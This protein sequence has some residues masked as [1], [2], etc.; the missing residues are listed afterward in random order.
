MPHQITT[1][2]PSQGGKG[3]RLLSRFANKPLIPRAERG[4]RRRTCFENPSPTCRDREIL[5]IT[6]NTEAGVLFRSIPA[7]GGVSFVISVV[8]IFSSYDSSET[9]CHGDQER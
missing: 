7:K 6:E 3:R 1:F 4:T 5:Q 8:G 9:A 2:Q